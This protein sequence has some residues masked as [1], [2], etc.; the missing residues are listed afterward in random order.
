MVFDILIN[1]KFYNSGKEK[2]LDLI[3]HAY[4]TNFS[5]ERS[6]GYFNSQGVPVGVYKLATL[7]FENSLFTSQIS[8]KMLLSKWLTTILI[9]IVFVI[10]ACMGNKLLV[11]NILQIAATGVLIQQTVRLQLFSNRMSAIHGDFKAL[12]TDLKNMQDK[13]PKEGEMIRN[14]LN[15][16]AT[17]SWGN[18]LLDSKL[19]TKMNP[20]LTQKWDKMKQDYNI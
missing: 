3:D 11:N 7:T 5:G 18:I 19:F 12:F 20:P 10:S 2:R 4:D 9:S 8:K 1:D 13:A 16:E 17:H 14:V 15:Y 6:I